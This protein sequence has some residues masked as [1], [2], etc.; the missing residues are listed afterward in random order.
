MVYRG[1][2]HLLRK[3][4][5]LTEAGYSSYLTPDGEQHG[6]KAARAL[7]SVAV[8]GSSD[9]SLCPGGRRLTAGH[10]PRAMRATVV[11][12]LT[13]S[14]AAGREGVASD[15]STERIFDEQIL[16]RAS[17]LMNRFGLRH[18]AV[19][20]I[21]KR[22]ARRSRS[23]SPDLRKMARQRRMSAPAAPDLLWREINQARHKP[24]R[25]IQ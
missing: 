20:G 15:L 4:P 9:F 25:A 22:S 17:R 8:A 2:E 13:R 21:H 19:R 3:R 16:V 1:A 7:Q 23:N 24:W 6:P 5:L 18:R 11:W 10:L 12:F 14:A